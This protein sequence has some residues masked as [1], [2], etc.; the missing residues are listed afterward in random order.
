LLLFAVVVA[1]VFSAP[2]TDAGLTLVRDRYKAAP[3]APCGLAIEV[4]DN[5][6]VPPFNRVERML[7][8]GAQIS[9]Q[10]P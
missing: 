8:P 1:A 10:L 7:T 5:V 6:V 4:P 3:P 2:S 9:T